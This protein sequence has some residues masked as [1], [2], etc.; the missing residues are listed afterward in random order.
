MKYYRY[1]S[2]GNVTHT[3]DVKYHDGGVFLYAGEYFDGD[4]GRLSYEGTYYLRAR[5]YSP[6]TGRFSTVDPARQGTNWY[7]YCGNNPIMRV[8]PSGLKYQEANELASFLGGTASKSTIDGGRTK[9][10]KITVGGSTYSSYTGSQAGWGFWQNGKYY[11][12]DTTFINCYSLTVPKPN[13]PLYN[14][15]AKNIANVNTINNNFN[16]DISN[17]KNIYNNNISTYSLI[18]ERTGVPAVLVAA[19]HYRESNANFNTYLHNGD[20]LGTPTVNVPKGK[21][22]NNFV[23]AAVDAL[24]MK[25]SFREMYKLTSDSTDIVAMCAYAEVY[26]GLGYY[27]NGR[28]SPYV[29]S[30]T[31]IYTS[32][33]YVSDGSF[34]ANVVDSQP[35]IYIL[36]K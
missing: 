26:N 15:T 35:G 6:R 31:N 9:G 32:G 5:S 7:S 23:D 21:N 20:P 1:D 18:A 4:T 24:S 34:K 30:G 16:N 29:Y 33:K 8:D 36:I 28:I 22:F 12:D 3:N 25:D 27:N 19:I 14:A 13:T 17:F 2:F 11:I 10:Y